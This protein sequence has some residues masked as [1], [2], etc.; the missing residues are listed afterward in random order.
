MR[1]FLDEELDI[2]DKEIAQV[3]NGSDQGLKNKY[4]DLLAD[5]EEKKRVAQARRTKSK[6]EINLRFA[7]TIDAQ[8][9]RFRV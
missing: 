8:W 7:V 2:V 1:L 4:R 9:S 3:K 6:H 5:F